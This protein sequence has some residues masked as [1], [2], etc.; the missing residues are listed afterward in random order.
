MLILRR[1]LSQLMITLIALQPVVSIADAHQFH[2]SDTEHL[3][4]EYEHTHSDVQPLVKADSI[5]PDIVP[6]TADTSQLD[7][8]HCCH[9]H[10]TGQ[11]LLAMNLVNS[12]NRQISRITS[13]HH[14][15]Y[16]S[17]SITPDN[18]PPIS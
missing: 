1:Y 6:D 2:Q 16:L 5:V 18:P 15:T 17:Y 11:V 10:G 14:V 8:Q 12:F 4:V 7:C 9:C 13:L 3:T